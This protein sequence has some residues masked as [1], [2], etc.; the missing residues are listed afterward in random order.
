V[1]WAVGGKGRA[2]TAALEAAEDLDDLEDPGES[3]G[4]PPLDSN[5]TPTALRTAPGFS[6]TSLHPT[7]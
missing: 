2:R 3:R 6:G 7:P 1:A 5:T 4:P